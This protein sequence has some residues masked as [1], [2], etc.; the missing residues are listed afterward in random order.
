MCFEALCIVRL[1]QSHLLITFA[2]HQHT[3]HTYLRFQEEGLALELSINNTY[4]EV[5]QQL[6]KALQPPLEDPLCL[7]F[8]QQHNY[9]QQPKATPL[10]HP[11]AAQ[12][13]QLLPDMLT[14]FQ[15]MA[16]TLFYEV[17]DLPLPELERLKT[18]KASSIY[19]TA[20]CL[21]P[22]C[23]HVCVCWPMSG[24]QTLVS[25]RLFR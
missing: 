22:C 9:S 20:Y 24:Y 5:S 16:D 1:T 23:I 10:R 2:A 18:L 6:A 4:E 17:L 8:T 19:S 21:L 14:Q 12:Q 11:G 3:S 13:D 7:R 25:R 15:Q